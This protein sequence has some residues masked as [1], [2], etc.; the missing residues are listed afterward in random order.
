MLQIADH[1]LDI[2]ENSLRAGASEVRISIHEDPASDKL[3]IRIKDNGSGMGKEEMDKV[4]DP[5]YSTKTARKR[6]FGLGLPL[7]AQM[8]EAAGGGV[9][10]VSKVGKGTTVT[11]TFGLSHIDRQPL[12]DIAGVFIAIILSKPMTNLTYIHRYGK[13]SF[14]ISTSHI[15]KQ[16]DETAFTNVKVLEAIKEAIVA[17]VKAT[18][19]R[20]V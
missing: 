16:I 17:G 15:K 11:A 12:G 14:E 10:I 18:G 7:F 6:K 13:K 20:F 8:A 5:F 9:K 4:F 19:S 1:I 2:T 3:I